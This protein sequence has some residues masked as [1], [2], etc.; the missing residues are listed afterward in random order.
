MARYYFNVRRGN[1]LISDPEGLEFGA[2][3]DAR[4][5]A[6]QAARDILA[7]RVKHGELVDDGEFEIIDER[8][9]KI[10][11]VP[12]RSVLRLD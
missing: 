1:D 11:T 2:V 7:D 9:V 12:F 6:K 3:D 5:E 4:E 8:G 10:L